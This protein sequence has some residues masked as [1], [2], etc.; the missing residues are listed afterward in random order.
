[1]QEELKKPEYQGRSI[2]QLALEADQADREA[3]K[4]APEGG[5]WD[6]L[7]NTPYINAITAARA[8]KQA[9]ENM[10]VYE[11]LFTS[12]FQPLLNSKPTNELA[13]ISK[14][15]FELDASSPGDKI[16]TFDQDEKN[17]GITL[18]IEK[19]NEIR[20]GFSVSAKKILDTAVMYLTSGNH[21]KS[22]RVNPTVEF[23]L[24][25]YLKACGY[26]L[27]PRKMDTP[28][29]QEAE[30]KRIKER[31]KKYKKNIEKDLDDLSNITWKGTIKSGNGAG[32]YETIRI[33]SSHSIKDGIVQINFDVQM[34][35]FLN[36]SYMMQFPNALLKV[37]NRNPNAYS[38]GRKIAFHNSNYNNFVQGT[39][40]TLTVKSLL[41]AAPDIISKGE[42]DE[43]GARNWREKIK[44]KLEKALTDLATVG[45]LKKWEYRDSTN[46]Q[47]L[48]PAAA[49][50]LSWKHYKALR[51]DFVLMQEAEV[52]EYM[53]KLEERK[54][55]ERAAA[56]AVPVKKKTP[57]RTTKK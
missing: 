18:K 44:D 12:N 22:D 3:T 27:E 55:A 11:N 23:R 8:A 47:V 38:I 17:R 19:Y 56:E 4:D 26:D 32:D 48:P 20:G 31:I 9:A 14:S 1:M 10:P 28:K 51:V 52:V 16:Y 24:A 34:A 42:L 37:D 6:A 50:K 41:D 5:T 30:N 54:A 25:D 40:N 21:Y 15:F 46:G 33:I 36:K 13:S 45:Y 7:D 53:R 49:S 29:E 35:V 43:R 57:R 39:N 2:E